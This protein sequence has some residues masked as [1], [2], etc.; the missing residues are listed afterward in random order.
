MKFH[1]D[2]IRLASGRLIKDFK[3]KTFVIDIITL[4]LQ[5][6]IKLPTRRNIFRKK[7]FPS[8]FQFNIFG[9]IF[10]NVNKYFSYVF[11]LAKCR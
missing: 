7:Y 8:S 10:L 11:R 4:N 9:N 2:W 3:T 5:E 1:N 6:I